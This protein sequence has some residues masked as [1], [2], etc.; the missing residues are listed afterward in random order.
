MNEIFQTNTENQ[1]FGQVFPDKNEFTSFLFSDSGLNLK[2]DN[3][4]SA[5]GAPNR[6]L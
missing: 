6:S 5:G 4:Q 1:V 3:S 2:I